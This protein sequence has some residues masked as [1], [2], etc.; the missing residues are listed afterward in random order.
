M[1]IVAVDTGVADHLVGDRDP[2]EA[3]AIALLGALEDAIGIAL[4]IRPGIFAKRV[5]FSLR[6][7]GKGNAL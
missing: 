5:Q 6:T 1:A 3:G 2:A 7:I 4:K